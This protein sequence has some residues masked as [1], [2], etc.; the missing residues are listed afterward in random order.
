MRSLLF[1]LL[2]LIS[3]CSGLAEVVCK[4]PL[5]Q[6]LCGA[7]VATDPCTVKVA[8]ENG[9]WAV[10]Y[11]K[12][13]PYSS[14]RDLNLVDTVC[15]GREDNA[16]AH[17]EFQYGGAAMPVILDNAEYYRY[18]TSCGCTSYGEKLYVKMNGAIVITL[19]CNK[20]SQLTKPVDVCQIDAGAEL[21]LNKGVQN[22]HDVMGSALVPFCSKVDSSTL[23]YLGQCMSASACDK[24]GFSAEAG[25]SRCGGNSVCCTHKDG[26]TEPRLDMSATGVKYVLPI[27]AYR[28]CDVVESSST[29]SFTRCENSYARG[30]TDQDVSGLARETADDETSSSTSLIIGIVV[31]SVAF[32]CC[33]AAIGGIVVVASMRRR[34]QRNGAHGV[35][36]APS[37]YATSSLGASS[38]A[39]PVA[40]RQHVRRPS[41]SRL[42][43][44]L[45]QVM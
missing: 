5:V 28:F 21:S 19:P 7:N 31:G 1:C 3:T 17:V 38:K 14:E 23:T 26:Y 18:Q 30:F 35:T 32:I 43:R 4:T 36:A 33:L 9:N 16:F 25:N 8:V 44:N 22:G 37:T 42:S 13:C 6:P 20:A 39:R 27:S 15:G 41:T 40:S 10:Y 12:D 29:C 2:S 24:I 45:G 11:S 34:R